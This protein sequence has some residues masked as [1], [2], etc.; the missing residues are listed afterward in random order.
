MLLLL[1]DENFNK[2]AF[3]SMISLLDSVSESIKIKIIH[4]TA[5]L[6]TQIPR[7]ILNHKGFIQ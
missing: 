5:N 4:N 3:T 1:F 6:K 7:I 2:Q